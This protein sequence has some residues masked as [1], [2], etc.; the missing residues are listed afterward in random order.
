MAIGN[1]E[2]ITPIISNLF[3]RVGQELGGENSPDVNS[4]GAKEAVKKAAHNFSRRS[5]SM[6]RPN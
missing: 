1:D 2:K 6:M 5:Q 4:R 3:H